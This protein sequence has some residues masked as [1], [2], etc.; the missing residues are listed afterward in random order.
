MSDQKT[1]ISTERLPKSSLAIIPA[2]ILLI[3]VLAVTGLR[4]VPEGN[5]GVTIEGGEAVGQVVL[6]GT[7]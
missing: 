5:M 6:D 7:G 2:A 1:D 4:I 3:G